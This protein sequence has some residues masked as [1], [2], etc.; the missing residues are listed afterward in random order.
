MTMGG[1]RPSPRKELFLHT[2]INGGLPEP[3]THSSSL[4][5]PSVMF[6]PICSSAS[7]FLPAPFLGESWF[8]RKVPLCSLRTP[9][10]GGV[11][12]VLITLPRQANNDPLSLM[13]KTHMH[14]LW[15]L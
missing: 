13:R 4:P 14:T 2:A 3:S 12:L 1:Q 11:R 7:G 6:S 9:I 15:L 10:E 8:A 5:F